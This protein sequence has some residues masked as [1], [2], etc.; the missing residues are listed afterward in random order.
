MDGATGRPLR[1]RILRAVRVR[2]MARRDRPEV[3]SATISAWTA[4]IGVRRQPAAWRTGSRRARP[5]NRPPLR[6]EPGAPT[7]S[8]VA[9]DLLCTAPKSLALG[10]NGRGVARWPARG[11]SRHPRYVGAGQH[12]RERGVKRR[13]PRGQAAARQRPERRQ[14][15]AQGQGFVTVP[16]IRRGSSPTTSRRPGSHRPPPACGR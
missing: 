14:T 16:R 1:A 5:V 9:K 3:R 15:P 12:G 4:F 13:R 6:L 7:S 10:S 2:A 8:P 11:G